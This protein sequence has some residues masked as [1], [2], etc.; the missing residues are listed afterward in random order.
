L[1]GVPISLTAQQWWWEV[2]YPNPDPTLRAV[3]ANEIHIPAGRKVK[4]E[5]RST[6][7]IHSFWVPNLAGKRDL[8]P[9]RVNV[10]WIQA[11][12]P[13]V[14]RGQCAEFCGYQHAH[15]A[16]FV[17]VHEAADFQ[18][19]LVNERRMAAELADSVRLRGQQ[20]FQSQACILCHTITGA[21]AFGA[22]GPN[23]T[24]FASRRSIGSAT[25]PN[26]AENLRRWI[27]DS[28]RFKPGNRMPP[29][30]IPAQDLDA[31]VEYL[32]SLQ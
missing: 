23:L 19:W 18:E 24:H 22:V 30:N 7:V 14:Y 6:D 25:L 3:S 10:T 26:T 13:G 29:L 11:D 9:G 20:V 1:D 31:L 4:I 16:L 28:Q 8:I 21:Q 5:L 2:V 12:R 15:M 17:V 32:R 27:S